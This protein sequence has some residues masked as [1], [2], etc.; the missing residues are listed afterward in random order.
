MTTVYL[1]FHEHD[2]GNGDSDDKLIGVYPSREEA[3]KAQERAVLLDGFRDVPEGFSIDA[4]ELG[5]D[6]WTTGYVT[7][8]C[9]RLISGSNRE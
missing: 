8:V 1:L 2:L 9:G 6:H 5:K 7:V 4:Y 3:L